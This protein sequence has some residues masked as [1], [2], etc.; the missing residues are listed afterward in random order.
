MFLGFSKYC[1]RLLL[2][3][4]FSQTFRIESKHI[5]LG[6]CFTAERFLLQNEP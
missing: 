5:L 4:I 1:T 3:F 2:S 6:K